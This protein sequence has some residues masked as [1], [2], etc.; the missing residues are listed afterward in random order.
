MTNDT[1]QNFIDE[2]RWRDISE[3]PKEGW[4]LAR[5]KE[6]AYANCRVVLRSDETD[7]GYDVNYYDDEMDYIEDA[8]FINFRPIPTDTPADVMQIAID[9]LRRI[10]E[11]QSCGNYN[12]QEALAQIE[13]RIGETK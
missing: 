12:A 5:G 11:E 3:S 8:S 9:A 13:A 1:I 2:Q 6:S 10:N 7:K 4:I